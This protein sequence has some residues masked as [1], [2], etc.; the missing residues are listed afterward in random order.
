MES[1]PATRNVVG[2]IL[3]NPELGRKAIRLRQ[4]GQDI[5][6][7]V[8]GKSVHPAWATPGGVRDMLPSVAD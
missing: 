4:F 8:T 7:M 6:R 1:D 3:A 2:L 5:I